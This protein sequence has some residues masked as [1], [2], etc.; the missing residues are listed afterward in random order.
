MHLTYHEQSLVSARQAGT[1]ESS[2]N[3]V[4]LFPHSGWGEDVERINQYEFYELGKRLKRVTLIEGDHSPTVWWWEIYMLRE[5][6]KRLLAGH[7]TPLGVSKMKATK[8]LEAV[9][10]MCARHMEITNPDGTRT[11]SAPVEGAAPMYAWEWNHLRDMITQFET[12]FSEEMREAA[13]YRVPSRGIYSTP[14]LIDSADEAFPEELLPFIP[15]KTRED[16]R[17]AGRCLAF[18]L[19]SASGFHVARAVEGIMEAYYQ[20]FTGKKNE[21]KS[22]NDY[23]VALEKV[24]QTQDPAPSPKT[25]EELRQMKNDYR[26]PILHPRI[27]LGVADARM[28]F[29]N[30]ESL[31]IGMAQELADAAV[32][33]QPDLLEA[34]E[35]AKLIEAAE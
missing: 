35:D 31:I 24:D 4:F 19:L 32:G 6:M 12:V 10:Q 30:G 18:N 7:P 14:K 29:A 27:V 11:F 23:I 25:I 2:E 16:W 33:I 28:L 34:P 15:E 17:S 3:V 22:W 9:D 8:M 13:T 1:S 20:R 26:N 21:L 5:A